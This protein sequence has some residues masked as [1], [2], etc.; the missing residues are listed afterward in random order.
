[1]TRRLVLFGVLV[2]AAAVVALV[3][4]LGVAASDTVRDGAIDGAQARSQETAVLISGARAASVEA[5]LPGSPSTPGT[6]TVVLPDD[7]VLG[8]ELGPASE[9][10][11]SAAR[12]GRAVTV[13]TGGGVVAASPATGP[14]GT[15]VALVTLDA[16]ELRAGVGPSLAALAMAGAVLMAAA[17][18]TAVTLARRTTAPLTDLKGVALELAEGTLD[19]RAAPSGVP[20]IAEVGVALNRLA[21]RVQELLAEERRSSA[22]LAHRLRTPLTALMVDLDAVH[23]EDVKERL[24]DD[25]DAVHTSV[26]EIITSHRR[27]E[28]EGVRAWCDAV[29]VVADRTAFW[30]V[31]AEDQQRELVVRLAPGP[32]P[33]RLAR[34]DLEAA[35]D[36][37]VQNVFVHTPEG[38]GMTVEVK[39]GA[40][41]RVHVV[42]E[43]A[44]PG[45]ADA[46]NLRRGST[47]LGLD[48]VARTAAASGGELR[49]DTSLAGGARIVLTLGS[50]AD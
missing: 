22:D 38:T 48:I 43:D 20:E 24:R 18:A 21:G 42:V 14:D 50:P 5:L 6:L 2:C 9:P 33:V 32:L 47:G 16:A 27:P 12:T 40:D 30:A 34:E 23:D 31:L 41:G 39:A 15:S 8:A 10:A 17:V 25:L 36:I 11:V 37:I 13:D 29:E 3:V 44:G 4:P 26:D 7:A 1:M 46:T 19:A 28:R 45:W 35:I 49:R